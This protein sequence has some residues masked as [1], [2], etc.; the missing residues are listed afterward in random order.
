[1]YTVKTED[2]YVST[3]F[4]IP[5]K[6]GEEPSNKKPVL[7]QH[8]MECDMNIF[9]LNAP[10]LSPAF[11]MA[12]NGYDVWLGN[13]R[14]NNFARFHVD[15]DTHTEEFWD[16]SWEEMGV[17]DT[18]AH[19]DFILEKTGYKQLTYIGHSEGTT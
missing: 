13:N 9:S 19:I 17:Y 18:P 4:R 8:G 15:L 2:G 16:F 10:E 1:M 7:M 3:L 11:I 12:E 5:G 14:G 6:L